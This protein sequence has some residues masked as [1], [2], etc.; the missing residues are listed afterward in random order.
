MLA[1]EV[2]SILETT[3][4]TLSEYVKAGKIRTTDIGNGH[5]DYN[6]EDV[7]N[8]ALS[9]NLIT[10]EKSKIIRFRNTKVDEA[11]PITVI[12]MQEALDILGISKTTLSTYLTSGLLPLNR[13]SVNG[14]YIYDKDKIV[15]FANQRNSR[16]LKAIGEL[17]RIIYVSNP[18]ANITEARAS[19][20]RDLCDQHNIKYNLIIKDSIDY[21]ALTERCA[22]IIDPIVQLTDS[23]SSLL[24]L[25]CGRKIKEI[26]VYNRSKFLSLSRVLSYQLKFNKIKIYDI[27]NLT[28]SDTAEPE[29]C[30]DL[31]ELT[32]TC[33]LV[34]RGLVR[35]RII[36]STTIDSA[37]AKMSV[38]PEVNIDSDSDSDNDNDNDNDNNILDADDSYDSC[39]SYDT[40]DG[41]DEDVNV[42][43]DDLSDMSDEE[44]QLWKQ[45]FGDTEGEVELVDEDLFDYEVEDPEAISDVE[46]EE[47]NKL[48]E[49][50]K[51]SHNGG[52]RI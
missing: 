23:F 30:R 52:T 12:T 10:A 4:S 14:A 15:K 8:L 40:I 2:L 29:L 38:D 41:L 43:D 11:E 32:E 17:D 39:D 7:C 5:Y 51:S 13:V 18:N 45:I 44:R 49:L 46:L 47:L 34:G 36:D 21:E 28:T 20:I 31:R 16:G 24:S 42:D 27:S 37:Q 26:Y 19:Y 48:N 3:R 22:S 6:V 50:N 25:L 9:K 33:E 1:G 35:R